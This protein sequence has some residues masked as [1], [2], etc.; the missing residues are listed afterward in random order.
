MAD[1]NSLANGAITRIGSKQIVS[2]IEGTR[3]A[4]LTIENGNLD[5][6]IRFVS[7]QHVWECL[8]EKEKLARST[9]TPVYGDTYKF[10]LPTR[11]ARHI[12]FYP[13]GIN[14]TRVGEFY[15]ASVLNLWMKFVRIPD[16]NKLAVLPQYVAD[17]IE[18]DLAARV[19]YAYVQSATQRSELK[20]EASELLQI[21][22]N[23][24][25]QDAKNYAVTQDSDYDWIAARAL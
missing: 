5:K 16:E 23:K 13:S 4:Q 25:A 14:A 24:D 8:S 20:K 9:N 17:A 10:A 12:E 21:A 19:C 15:E 22:K 6:S 7:E 11:F 3:E 18:A 2:A 1:K